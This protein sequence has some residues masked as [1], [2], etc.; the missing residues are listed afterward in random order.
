MDAG[1]TGAANR[2][3]SLLDILDRVQQAQEGFMKN[4][5]MRRYSVPLTAVLLLSP[6][7]AGGAQGVDIVAIDVVAVAH[8][9]RV[10]QLLGRKVINEQNEDIGKIDDFIIDRD[11]VLF[12]ILEVG[13][14]L[15]IGAH[16]VALPI[17]AVDMDSVKGKIRIEGASRDQ[18]KKMPEFNYVL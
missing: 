1:Q 11:R 10:S 5:L 15:G 17:S 4:A 16:R 18:L 12:V 2:R 6:H 9:H 7:L 14:F 13:G 8:G 3:V